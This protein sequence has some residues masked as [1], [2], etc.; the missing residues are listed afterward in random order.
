MRCKLIAGNW[1]MN[2]SAECIRGLLDEI[3]KGAV[4]IPSVELAVFPPFVYLGLV[5]QQL[6]GTTISWGTQN[7]SEY[8]AGPYTGEVASQML[9][10][11]NCQYA[12]VGHSERRALYGESDQVVAR[13]FAA[14]LKLGI[15]PI[16]C[17]GE[18]LAEREQGVTEHVIERQIKAVLDLGGI[19]S[20]SDAV[21]AYEPVWAIGTGKTAT[22][23]QAQEVHSF[24]RSKLA[25]HDM[26]FPVDRI[27]I[28]YGGSMKPANASELLAMP[29]VD[30]G[31][32]GGASLEAK[33][34]LA[35]AK[36]CG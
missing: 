14:A 26:L 5:A 30:G 3:R 35:I 4:T 16:L 8:A 21:I 13:K 1:K 29:D 18:T 28:L 31:L 36:A 23:E 25:A 19:G 27:R 12:I 32:I 17:V 33:E 15:R 6:S 2:G 7:I 20:F 11:F 24:I 22:S 34:F 9:R 10:D